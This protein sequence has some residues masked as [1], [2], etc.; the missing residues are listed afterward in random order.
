M[1]LA[2]FIRG[3]VDA[4]ESNAAIASKLGIDQTTIA[5]HLTLLELAPVLADAWRSGRC[6]S[7]RTLHELNQL[8]ETDP[9]AVVAVLEGGQPLTR[10]AVAALKAAPSDSRSSRSAVGRLHDVASLID[11]ANRCCDRLAAIFSQMAR[12]P[13]APD[14]EAVV[15]LRKR[16]ARMAKG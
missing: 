5:H 14:E 16:L 11:Q 2:R 3:R 13:A 12:A 7:P 1:D 10:A 15:A 4:G 8:H 9:Q 6:T